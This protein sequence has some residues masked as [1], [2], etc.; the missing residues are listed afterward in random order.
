MKY[1]VFEALDPSFPLAVLEWG[2]DSD[3]DSI[4]VGSLVS[5]GS[6]GTHAEGFDDC[7]D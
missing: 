1:A 4:V 6:A 3:L 2:P 7:L 5:E